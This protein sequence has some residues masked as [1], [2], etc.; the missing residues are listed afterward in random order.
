[1]V[2]CG[3]RDDEAV[4]FYFCGG[5]GRRET[6]LQPELFLGVRTSRRTVENP[7]VSYVVRCL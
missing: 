2:L 4:L 5:S 1:M 7:S 3:G 6:L